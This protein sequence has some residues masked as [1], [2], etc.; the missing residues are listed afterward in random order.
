M[1]TFRG[2]IT[3]FAFLALYVFCVQACI[4]ECGKPKEFEDPQQFMYL[5]R[6]EH[7]IHGYIDERGFEH[8]VTVV[9]NRY[10]LRGHYY[11]MERGICVHLGDCQTCKDERDAALRQVA[12]DMHE[13]I[14]ARMDALLDTLLKVQA[15]DTKQI[16]ALVRQGVR[17]IKREMID[18]D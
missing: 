5:G 8:N 16:K 1:R 4:C 15:T 14:D 7:K 12:S 3:I 10:K 17:D 9:E 18:Y 13:Y 11:S 6:Q 2:I